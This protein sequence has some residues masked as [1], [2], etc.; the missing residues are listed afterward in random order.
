MDISQIFNLATKGNAEAQNSMGLECF[1]KGDYDNAIE[2]WN[3]SATQ[4]NP[5]AQYNLG[6]CYYDGFCVERNL[7]LSR[8]YFIKASAL[9]HQPSIDA[10]NRLFRL[11]VLNCFPG[12]DDPDFY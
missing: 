10:L 4:G 6:M 1:G 9:N 3:K 8:E 12:A 2:W 5:D 11:K 7:D